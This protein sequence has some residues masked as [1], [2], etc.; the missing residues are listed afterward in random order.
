M[1]LTSTLI[2]AV[3]LAIW[4]YLALA[5][6]NFWRLDEDKIESQPLACWPRVAAIIPAR[7]EAESIVQTIAFL[8][9]QD[10]PGDFSIIVV[11]DHSEDG[12]AAL[13]RKAGEESGAT[14]RVTVHTAAGLTSGWTGKLWALN[15]GVRIASATAPDFFWFTDADIVH[16]PET[17]RRLVFRA[18]RDSLDLA[19][20]MVL[21]QAKTFPERLLI[22]PFLYFF[23]MLY[24][25]QWIAD[26]GSR[27]AGAAGGCIL[28]RREALKR[29]GGF[30]AIR[31]QVIDDCALA[32]AV[33]HGGG[34]IWMGLTRASVS[35]RSYG[36]FSEI[37]DLIARTA[38]TQLRYS[39]FLLIGTLIGLFATYLL[40]WISFFTMED[41]AWILG[42]TAISLMTVTFLLTVKF[43]NLSPAWALTLPFAAAFYGYA[44]C[45]SAVRYWLGR[46]GQWKG[47]S[48]APRHKTPTQTS[49]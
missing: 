5:R 17:L 37:R 1:P 33:K 13:A 47:R 40:P 14:G 41:P 23:L 38:F 26:S 45:A 11:D 39:F 18:E 48:Q 21:L 34:E 4:I 28:L 2:S 12:T 44:T 43:Y 9:K 24:P 46:G 36:S 3:P 29:V 32:R 8:A 6:G 7:N 22:P 31:N 20:L 16:A 30:S 15:E 42:S 27:T 35:L 25:P 10:Y 19:S 49:G